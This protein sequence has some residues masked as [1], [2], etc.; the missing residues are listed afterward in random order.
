MSA[1]GH[2]L[3][4][5][6]L[7]AGFEGA[8]HRNKAGARLDMIAASQHDTQVSENYARLRGQGIATIRDGARWNLID[9]GDG[10]YDF[11]SLE[12]MVKA[13]REQ[14]MQ[15]IWTLCHYGWPDDVEVFSDKFVDRFSKYAGAVARYIAEQTGGTHFY[16]P[17]NEI[18]F[19]AGS[20][21]E[22]GD[23]HPYEHGRGEEL[24][25]QL[26]KAAIA[27]ASA[28]WEADPGARMVHVDPLVHIIAPRDRPDLAQ[29][30]A[31]AQDEQFEAFKMLSGQ[32]HPELGG[33]ARHLDIIG[34][35]FYAGNQ[36][37]HFGDR[38]AW[39]E[40]PRDERWTPLHDLIAD[41]A[42]RFPGHPLILSETSHVGVGRAEWMREIADE[43]AKIPADVDFEGICLYPIVDR[44]DWND[45]G[46]WHNSG[47][48][49][50]HR[51]EDGK[52]T[53]VINEPYAD[54]IRRAQHRFEGPN[55]T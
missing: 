38:L 41:V 9:K 13:A 44:P 6:F 39:H 12:P 4:K 46:H 26:V 17:V 36:W 21:G 16:T 8:T 14:G 53:R 49:D 23:F 51:E 29:D 15:V 54:E 24:R 33:S 2:K 34:L 52:Y 48:W 25:R 1:A 42:R 47:L 10:V 11:S 27:G 18:S 30:A 37:E 35:N 45:P 19:C 40:K 22:W 28:I 5:S 7:M 32:S 31:K 3:F 50:F 20:A 55:L 43:V